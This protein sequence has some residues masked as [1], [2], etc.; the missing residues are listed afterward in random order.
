MEPPDFAPPPV[1]Q[2]LPLATLALGL[3]V[4]VFAGFLLLGV[5]AQLLSIAWGLWFTEAFVFFALPFITLKLAARAPSRVTGLDGGTFSG[6][7]VGALL[8]L[9]N[10][11]GWAVPLMALAE[12]AFPRHIIEMFD[13]SAI[14]KNQT[15][16]E[17]GVLVAGVSLAAPVCEEFFFRGVVQHGLTRWLGGW[18]GIFLTALIFSAFHFDPVGFLARFELG[19]LFGWLFWK[20]G[21]LW[22]G[23]AAHAANNLTSTIIYFATRGQP[24]ADLP[25]WAPIALCAVGSGLLFGAVELVARHPGWLRA[26]RPCDEGEALPGALFATVLPWVGAALVSVALLFAVDLRG[27]TLNIFDSTHPA[28]APKD[29]APAAERAAWDDLMALRLKARTGE[30]PV[31]DYEQL[32][33][34]AADGQTKR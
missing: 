14:F 29:D 8:G 24:E 5:P 26:R 2:R 7:A 32:R 28:K 3:L 12:K 30:V 19:L 18:R 20:S 31:E 10:Y 34:L 21:S 9:V 25:D 11:V 22:P 33:A 27:V 13:G 17:L 23:V 4:G 1:P 15:S 6:V 16:V